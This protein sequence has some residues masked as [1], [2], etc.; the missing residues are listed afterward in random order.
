MIGRL[1]AVLGLVAFAFAVVPTTVASAAG[2]STVSVK[3]VVPSSSFSG[4]VSSQ[5]GVNGCSYDFLTFTSSYPGSAAV[6]TVNLNVAGCFDSDAN[7]FTGSYTITTAVG[8]LSG[9]AS[10]P[11]AI[12]YTTTGLAHLRG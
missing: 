10:G 5:S 2:A 12:T 4:A 3:D 11:V 9:R 7:S 6:G 1:L 8:T